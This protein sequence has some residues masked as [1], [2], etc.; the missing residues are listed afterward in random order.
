MAAEAQHADA[1]TR[2]VPTGDALPPPHLCRT[3][4]AQGASQSKD[5]RRHAQVRTGPRVGVGEK[6]F[7]NLGE[8]PPVGTDPDQDRLDLF[9]GNTGLHLRDLP[10]HVHRRTRPAQRRRAVAGDEVSVSI[11][12]AALT[13][14]ARVPTHDRLTGVAKN[15]T[16]HASGRSGDSAAFTVDAAVFF[17]KERVAGTTQRSAVANARDF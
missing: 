12:E 15:E 7:G 4:I 10:C 16:E 17:D 14:A 8:H 13:D 1:P 3:D 6:V 5:D 2:G 9:P 11:P